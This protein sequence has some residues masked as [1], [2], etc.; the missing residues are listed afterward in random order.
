MIAAPSW[1]QK[2]IRFV[3]QDVSIGKYL[4]RK[5]IHIKIFKV[6]FVENHNQKQKKRNYK[7]FNIEILRQLIYSST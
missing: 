4:H 3:F 7:I 2:Y 1:L 5:C 6:T